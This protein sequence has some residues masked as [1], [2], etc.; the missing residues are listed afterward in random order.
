MT[1]EWSDGAPF[2]AEGGPYGMVIDDASGGDGYVYAS[3]SNAAY[4]AEA[5]GR[6]TA[7]FDTDDRLV[8]YKVRDR[9]A[10]H[11]AAGVAVD[12]GQLVT[13]EADGEIFLDN[14]DGGLNDVGSGTYDMVLRGSMVELQRG[15]I[16][17]NGEEVGDWITLW[18]EDCEFVVDFQGCSYLKLYCISSWGILSTMAAQRQYHWEDGDASV[19][20]IVERLFALAGFDLGSKSGEASSDISSLQPAVVVHPGQDIRGA[21]LFALSK[22]GDFIY[23]EGD[24]PYAK[25]LEDDEASDYT[26]GGSGN[27]VIIAGSYGVRSPAYNHIQVLSAID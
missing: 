4:R 19:W 6:G 7:T 18:L 15:Y 25:E 12:Y 1:T 16:T 9:W 21:I 26:Y 24:T 5:T 23:F 13:P 17:S 3:C 10:G 8:K 11:K 14:S 20:D 27:H 2:Q 22:V